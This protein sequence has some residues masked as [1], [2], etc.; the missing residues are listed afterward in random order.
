MLALIMIMCCMFGTFGNTSLII[1][2][3]EMI[4]SD[5]SAFGLCTSLVNSI[6]D[7]DIRL[8]QS[9]EWQPYPRHHCLLFVEVPKSVSFVMNQ[10]L[11]SS[12]RYGATTSGQ[13]FQYYSSVIIPYHKVFYRQESHRHLSRSHFRRYDSH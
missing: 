6:P 10:Q 4:L 13:P 5:H 9:D 12:S 8:C 2:S 7:A 1:D 11:S 3:L